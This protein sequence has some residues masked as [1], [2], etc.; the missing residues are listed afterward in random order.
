MDQA[1]ERRMATKQPGGPTDEQQ[2]GGPKDDQRDIQRQ[3]VADK[4]RHQHVKTPDKEV[5]HPPGM[6]ED[7]SRNYVPE[8]ERP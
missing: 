1:M 4:D 3:D 2:H 6:G 7:E 8:K 5:A